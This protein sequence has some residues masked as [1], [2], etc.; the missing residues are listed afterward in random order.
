[1]IRFVRSSSIAPGKVGDAISFAKQI[2]EF[3]GKHYGVKLEVM[4]PVGGNPHRVAWRAE[5]PD[6]AALEKFQAKVMAD[7]KYLK[8]LSEGQANFIAGSANDVIWRTL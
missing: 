7:P 2:S 4:M 3:V 6:L 5:Y 8:L 1:M